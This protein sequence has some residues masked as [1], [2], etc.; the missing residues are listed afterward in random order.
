[1]LYIS[2]DFSPFPLIFPPFLGIDHL[3][4]VSMRY[5]Y[6]KVLGIGIDPALL[7]ADEQASI[8]SLMRECRMASEA[9]V[10][11]RN[12]VRDIFAEYFI[13]NPLRIGGPGHT[14]E[15][16]ESAFVRYFISLKI[17]SGRKWDQ[18]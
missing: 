14:V 4:N 11:W 1:M 2:L 13:R 9:I 18:N 15:I 7:Y 6:P 16:D 8:A 3:E 10:N 12:Y 17:L 5:R